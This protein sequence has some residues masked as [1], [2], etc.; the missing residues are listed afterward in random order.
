MADAAVGDERI[1]EGERDVVPGHFFLPLPF[2]EPNVDNNLLKTKLTELEHDLKVRLGRLE[3]LAILNVM[4]ALSFIIK[5]Y[6]SA[7]GR[8]EDVLSKDC[9]NLNALAN[10][11]DVLEKLVRRADAELH[12]ATLDSLLQVGDAMSPDEIKQRRCRKARCLAEQA[13]AYACDIHVDRPGET[14]YLQANH[15]YD[16]AFQL[17]GDLVDPLERDNWKFCKAKNAHK[18]VKF[19]TYK[20]EFTEAA[21]NF[22]IAENLFFE[23]TQS[24]PGDAE[25]KWES[26]RNLADLIR[27]TKKKREFKNYTFRPELNVY[28]DDPEECMKKAAEIAPENPKM[29]ARYANFVHSLKK[30]DCTKRA[31]ELLQRSI[32]LDSTE[33]NFYA[34]STRGRINLHNYKFCLGEFERGNPRYRYSPGVKSLEEAKTDFE[35]A[36]GMRDTPWDYSYLG[37]TYHLLAKHSKS[38]NEK[39]TVIRQ[40]LEKA[41]LYFR[42]A[43][44]CE[45]GE[46]RTMVHLLQGLCLFDMGEYLAAIEYFKKA[47]HCEPERTIFSGNFAELLKGYLQLLRQPPAS[48]DGPQMEEVVGD[49]KKAQ[50]KY[51]RGSL[52]KHT[53]SKLGSEYG[54]E[55]RTIAEYCRGR[56]EHA[57]LVPL[58]TSMAEKLPFSLPV[59][60]GGSL[61]EPWRAS[62]EHSVHRP[63]GAVSEAVVDGASASSTD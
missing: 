29:W 47:I 48:G 15:L 32:D 61:E 39:D 45:D 28:R 51:G 11:K 49:L 42:K 60:T 34:F 4:G 5:D 59:I 6:E 56:P 26:W 46:T 58:L 24:T 7:L 52:E 16:D 50:I 1:E 21:S 20:G 8:F 13:Y 2:N 9:N 40:Y 44:D 17:G 18:I 35:K 10:Q 54:K 62:L 25:F 55:I 31:M 14:R 12:Q 23:V 3:E 19:L 53:I 63:K 38:Q 37:E 36:L 22:K 43:A 27:G 41:L 33:N 30:K 57:E